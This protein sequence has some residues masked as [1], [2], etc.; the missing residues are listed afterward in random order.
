M[1]ERLINITAMTNFRR[2]FEVYERKK[3]LRQPKKRNEKNFIFMKEELEVPKILKKIL[4]LAYRVYCANFH[5]VL[6]ISDGLKYVP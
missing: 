3:E 1:N 2:K 6:D 5:P 4:M